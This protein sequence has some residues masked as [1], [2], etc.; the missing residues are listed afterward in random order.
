MAGWRGTSRPRRV[1][2]PVEPSHTKLAAF[3]LTN[4]SIASLPAFP[5]NIKD[6]QTSDGKSFWIFGILVKSEEIVNLNSSLT[7]T[8]QEIQSFFVHVFASVSR[9]RPMFVRTDSRLT[10]PHLQPQLGHCLLQTDSF[11]TLVPF[12]LIFSYLLSL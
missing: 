9:E 4:H 8:D 1:R 6:I 2:P 10:N 7:T 12:R 5:P 3:I 11:N